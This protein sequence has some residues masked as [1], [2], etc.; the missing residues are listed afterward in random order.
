MWTRN[1]ERTL[2]AVLHRIEEVI[3]KEDV[4]KKIIIDDHSCDKTVEIAKRFG[5][6]VYPNPQTGIPSGANEALR[7]VETEFFISFEQDVLL[8]RD[9]WKKIPRYMKDPEVAVS[10]GIRVATNPVLRKLD[11]Y[12]EARGY[13]I[14]LDNDIYRTEMIRKI[15]GF[16]NFC[17]VSV[18]HGL[19][20]EV[21]KA[22]YKWIIDGTVVSD[23]IRTSVK[24]YIEHET[25]KALFER[26]QIHTNLLRN[27]RLFVTSPLSALKIVLRKKCPQIFLIYPY[28]RLMRLR[29]ILQGRPRRKMLDKLN[30]MGE[31]GFRRRRLG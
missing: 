24:E 7:H 20:E 8:S 18:D 16:P 25:R 14:C 12:T 29:A 28:Y 3:P 9:W 13:R 17:P 26:R 1:G 21:R 11:E 15:G 4:N 10:H 5:W 30:E 23:H 27:F 2:E 22:G 6:E 19:R 31:K